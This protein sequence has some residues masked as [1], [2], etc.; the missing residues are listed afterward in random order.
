MTSEPLST[1]L[2]TQADQLRQLAHLCADSHPALA[3]ALVRHAALS[4]LSSLAAQAL[5]RDL[6][7]ARATAREALADMDDE[8]AI[9]R[10]HARSRII[11]DILAPVLKRSPGSPA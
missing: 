11:A 7:T 8:A 10:R 3:N 2:L 1:R 4:G 5:E 9:T 6:R